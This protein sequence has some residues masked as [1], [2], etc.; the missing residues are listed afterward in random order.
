MATAEK[1]VLSTYKARMDKAIAALKDEFGSL[2]TGRASASLLD[3]IHVEAYGSSVPLN[4]VG[5]VSV[6]E[7]RM[8]T[9]NV[10]D[11]GLVVSVEKAIR[12]SDLGLNPVVDGTTLRLPIPPLTEERRKDLAKLAGK[13]AEQQRI[14]V[15]NVRRDANDDCRKAEKDHV[16]SQ[17]E[18]KRMETEVQKITDEAIKRIDEALKT[19]EQEIMQV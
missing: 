14:A 18:E 19:K 12:A 3:Q 10:W 7:P 15:R 9:I 6:P 13:Y 4:Q 2:R 16:I 17:D 5:A 11:R 1:P 8:I